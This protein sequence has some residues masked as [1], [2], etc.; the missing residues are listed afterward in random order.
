MLDQQKVIHMQARVINYIQKKLV[1]PSIQQLTH[2]DST[3]KLKLDHGEGC[4][5]VEGKTALENGNERK[6]IC[7]STEHQGVQ[8]LVRKCTVRAFSP[9]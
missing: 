9:N 5:S 1:I 8:E 4:R 2:I 3:S 7:L 6:M